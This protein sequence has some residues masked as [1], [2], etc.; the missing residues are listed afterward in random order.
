MQKSKEARILKKLL[1]N[2]YVDC[3]YVYAKDNGEPYRVN[4]VT[5]QFKKFLEDKK[6]EKIRFHDLRHSVASILYDKKADIKAIADW[7]G[8]SDISTT[9]KI[10]AHRFDNTQR[11]NSFINK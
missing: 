3:D 5:E 9:T 11:G 2:E 10:Y 8:H 4:S 7:L 6:L 1:K